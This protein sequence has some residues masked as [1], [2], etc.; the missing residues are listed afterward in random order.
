MPSR[1]WAPRALFIA[2]AVVACAGSGT[3]DP[4][5]GEARREVVIAPDTV[6]FCIWNAARCQ[7]QFEE[8]MWTTVEAGGDMD[9]TCAIV[10]GIIAAEDRGAPPVEWLA[11]REP[12]P[13]LV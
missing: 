1:E 2:G 8:A 10:G 13:E 7:G 11:R 3:R 9:T 6:P 12:L 4:R 5:P